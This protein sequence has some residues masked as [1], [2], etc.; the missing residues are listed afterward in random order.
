LVSLYSWI[1]Q[2]RDEKHQI[3]IQID[4]KDTEDH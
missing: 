2:L 1:T 4:L 3:P